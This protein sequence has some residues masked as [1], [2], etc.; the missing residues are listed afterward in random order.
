MK[1]RVREA[2]VLYFRATRLARGP[3]LDDLAR[4]HSYAESAALSAWINRPAGSNL[5]WEA[6]PVSA[7]RELRSSP[8]ARFVRPE[9]RRFP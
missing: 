8:I 3:S 7:R 2:Y 1:R 4:A 5:P 6:L 9:V